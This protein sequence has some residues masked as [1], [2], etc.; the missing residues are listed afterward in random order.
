MSTL[1]VMVGLSGTGKSTAAKI[2][3]RKDDANIHK[4]DRIRKEIT[5]GEPTYSGDES[6]KVYDEL[7]NR[8]EKD[9]KKGNNVVLDATFSLEIGRRS[10]E[11]MAKRVGA[12]MKFVRITCRESTVKKRIRNRTDTDSDADV[13]V[14]EAQKDKFESLSRD[15]IEIDNSGSKRSLKK[16]IERDVI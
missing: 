6:Q 2:I 12:D 14:Y 15:H 8:G 16:K 11:K 7:F 3:A 13:E 4:T 5:S 9:L 1:Y 10:V